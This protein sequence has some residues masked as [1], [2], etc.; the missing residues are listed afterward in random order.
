MILYKINK[1]MDNTE[2]SGHIYSSLKFGI[3]ILNSKATVVH[4]FG[5]EHAQNVK[6]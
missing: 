6:A 3:S 5:I 1:T 2:D 4:P